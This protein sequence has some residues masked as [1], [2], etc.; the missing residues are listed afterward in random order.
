DPVKL[1]TDNNTKVNAAIDFVKAQGVDAKDIKTSDYNLSPNYIWNQKTGKS[2]IDGYTLNQSVS[3]KVRDL[4]KVSAILGGL[5]AKGIN[6]IGGVNFSI[7]DQDKYLNVA[8]EEAFTKARAKAQAMA[9]YSGARIGRVVTFSESNGG[10][11]Y[12]MYYAKEAS[13]GRGG[14]AQMPPAPVIE[15]GSQDV[16]VNVSVVYE[17]R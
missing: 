16:T 5:P 14:D 2:T 13:V 9:K 8:R 7:E 4:G 12:P 3:V 10:Y 6:Q 15:P 17:L 1:Q 11:P